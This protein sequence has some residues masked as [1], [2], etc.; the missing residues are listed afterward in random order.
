MRNHC[1]AASDLQN[2]A[3]FRWT[4][5][6]SQINSILDPPSLPALV[7]FH[8]TKKSRSPWDFGGIQLPKKATSKYSLVTYFNS[9][10][11]SKNIFSQLNVILLICPNWDISWTLEV[12]ETGR[13][14][15]KRLGLVAPTMCG[16]PLCPSWWQITPTPYLGHRQAPGLL[17]TKPHRG[18]RGDKDEQTWKDHLLQVTSKSRDLRFHGDWICFD[19]EIR[20]IVNTFRFTVHSN[21]T[22][23]V[24]NQICSKIYFLHRKSDVDMNSIYSLFRR[25]KIFK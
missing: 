19:D 20:Y 2:I 15:W 17:Y 9:C 12:F 14:R 21:S 1:L 25:G 22:F 5:T 7:N 18:G 23:P 13:R 24:S 6:S 8:L 4:A 10:K 11:G 16:S 3:S